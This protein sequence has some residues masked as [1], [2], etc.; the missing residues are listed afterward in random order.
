MGTLQIHLTDSQKRQKKETQR[1][2]IVHHKPRPS[3]D[4]SP[5]RILHP[6]VVHPPPLV[7]ATD[8]PLNHRARAEVVPPRGCPRS[9][10]TKCERRADTHASDV[11]LLAP[12]VEADPRDVEVLEVL[13]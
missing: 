13:V 10:A 8:A 12:W 5:A 2:P 7:R 1:R 4:G 11:H 9:C 3:E 6:P